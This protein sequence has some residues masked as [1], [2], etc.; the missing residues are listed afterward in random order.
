MDPDSSDRGPFLVTQ[1]GS[2][3]GDPQYRE[4]FWVLR[5]NGSWADMNYYLATGRLDS[6]DECLF[7]NAAA[8]IQKLNE[9]TNL[10]QVADLPVDYAA[11]HAAL[12]S[13][14]QVN[15]GLPRVRAWISG[16]KDK[17]RAAAL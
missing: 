6:L 14:P 5:R 7:D 16:Y 9:L 3:P 2:T 13:H 11:L 4:I 10:V 15:P 1:I 17:H 12:G 8:V